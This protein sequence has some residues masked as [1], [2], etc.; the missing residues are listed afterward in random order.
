MRAR[1][2]SPVCV[3]TLNAVAGTFTTSWFWAGPLPD[4]VRRSLGAPGVG[5]GACDGEGTAV[6]GEIWGTKS[7]G[8]GLFRGAGPGA[9]TVS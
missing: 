9:R 4:G 1:G 7:Y 8:P 3:P 5:E 2:N 6:L